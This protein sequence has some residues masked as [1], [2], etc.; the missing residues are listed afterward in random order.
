MA[1]KRVFSKEHKVKLAGAAKKRWA[2]KHKLKSLITIADYDPDNELAI[3]SQL[4]IKLPEDYN[5]ATSHSY[6]KPNGLIDRMTQAI[7]K[8]EIQI[9]RLESL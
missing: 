2:K 6:D 5:V 4:R 8:I 1:K 3:G 7:D 9:K